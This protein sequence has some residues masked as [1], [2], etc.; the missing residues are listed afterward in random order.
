M[1]APMV[2]HAAIRIDI[3]LPH[4]EFPVDDQERLGRLA[5]HLREGIIKAIGQHAIAEIGAADG[6]LQQLRINVHDGLGPAWSPE[7]GSAPII[8][9]S[10]SAPDWEGDY[11]LE[12]EEFYQG[13]KKH[14]TVF[15][16]WS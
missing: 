9:G 8:P 7:G 2:G 3:H 16:G 12:C 1:K 10:L 13:G 4:Y 6:I 11:S 14:I 15:S 5:E